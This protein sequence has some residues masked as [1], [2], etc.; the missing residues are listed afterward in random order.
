MQPCQLLFWDWQ[1]VRAAHLEVVDRSRPVFYRIC[2]EA[3]LGAYRVRK[4]SGVEG[5]KPNQRVWWFKSLG[6]AEDF[7]TKKVRCK[8]NPARKSKRKY[9]L[10]ADCRGGIS[11]F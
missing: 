3:S 1:T 4:E 2:V 6:D 7:F 11:I 5:W 8:T 9:R 10:A